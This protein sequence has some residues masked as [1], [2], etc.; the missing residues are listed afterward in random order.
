VL[1]AFVGF[2]AVVFVA[3][4]IMIYKAVSTFG[5]LDTTDAYRKGLAYNERIAAASSQARRGW[6]DSLDYVPQS[7]RLRVALTDG[8]GGAV[9]G[10]TLTAEIM[11]PAT[12]RFDQVLFLQQTG[13]G[14]YEVD[15]P[16][17]A[18]GWWTVDLKAH[19]GAPE[20]QETAL[21]ESR[22]RLWITP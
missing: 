19:K 3:D 4:G 17:L 18:G 6:R 11:R 16:G 22:R 14:T 2:F 5:G 9:S 12:S 7:K 15:V 13:P 20:N 21:Y 10:L 8:A 1:L